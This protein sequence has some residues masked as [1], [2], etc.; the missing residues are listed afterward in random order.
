MGSWHKDSDEGS[1]PITLYLCRKERQCTKSPSYFMG[2]E[3][4]WFHDREERNLGWAT[5]R[6]VQDRTRRAH[7]AERTVV[8]TSLT[9]FA[10]AGGSSCR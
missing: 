1:I 10:V 2:T 5:S 4:C 7:D 6:E 3:E 8:T 9:T